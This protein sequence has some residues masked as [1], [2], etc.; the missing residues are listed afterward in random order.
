MAGIFATR[1]RQLRPWCSLSGELLHANSRCLHLQRSPVAC[2]RNASRDVLA[3]A[4]AL[5]RCL[6][7]QR[8]ALLANARV[9]RCLQTQ[10]TGCTELAAMRHCRRKCKEHE[11]RENRSPS[12]GGHVDDGCGAQLDE[13]VG[14]QREHGVGGAGGRPDLVECPAARGRT[15]SAPVPGGRTAGC[16]RSRSPSRHA[17]RRAW[18]GGRVRPRRSVP[19]A[20]PRRRGSRPTSTRAPARRRRRRT[21]ATSRSPRPRSRSQRPRRPRCACPRESAS[22][23]S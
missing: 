21:R 19:R 22:R 3:N 18:P 6:Q 10:G 8:I 7:T 1:L 16:R 17:P 9:A 5:R 12:G 11:I 23:R 4:R 15:R 14:G 2:K 20:G 13:A